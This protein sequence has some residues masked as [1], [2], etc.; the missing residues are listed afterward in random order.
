[1]PDNFL[2]SNGT[3]KN[4]ARATTPDEL[5]SAEERAVPQRR[6]QLFLAPPMP[7]TFDKAHL[8]AIHRHLFQDIFEWA[9]R[10]RDEKIRLSDKTVATMPVMM[11]VGGQ[12]FANGIEIIRELTSLFRDLRDD[13]FLTGLS[14]DDFANKAADT[15]S[16]LNAI[17]PF[18]EGN[19]RTQRAFIESLAIGAGHK[20]DFSVVST[21]RNIDVSIRSHQAGD[22]DAMR[23]LFREIVAP[24]RVAQLRLAQDSLD[25]AGFAW[26]DN[27]M[28][29]L[30]PGRRYDNLTF[31]AAVGEQFMARTA[32]QIL[33][34]RCADLPTP[35]P[36]RGQSFSVVATAFPVH[37]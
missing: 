33:I 32:D 34:G 19:G 6:R 1:M 5:A 15:F 8:L 31:V 28:A 35:A 2:T 3:L 23:R 20:L 36:T 7:W 14:R 4:I 30:E 22:A 26:R 21:E 16:H 37:S 25:K 29:T 27:Y 18:R 11:K 13:K 24:E 17:H 12:P 9:G 10:T